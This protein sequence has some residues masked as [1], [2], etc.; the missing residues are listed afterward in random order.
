MKFVPVPG[1]K[2]QFCIHETRYQDYAAHA[3][4][5]PGV[6][7]GWRN[8]SAEGLTPTENKESHPVMRVSWEDAQKFCAWLSQKEGKAYRLPTDKE[9]SVAAGIGRE[10][11]WEPGTLPAIVTGNHTIFPWGDDYPPPPGSG[12]FSDA[13]RKSKATYRAGQL[14]LDDFNDGFPTTAPVMS[15]KPN[16][17]GLYDLGG[18]VWEWV[19]D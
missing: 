8:Q 4:A 7:G 18:N 1:T 16:A 9:W 11:T 2:V 15:F 3:A 13:S 14:F 12:N 5:T 10:E 17:L 6:D 19:A